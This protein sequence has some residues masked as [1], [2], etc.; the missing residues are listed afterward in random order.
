MVVDDA[1]GNICLS[2][3]GGDA[4]GEDGEEGQEGSGAAGGEVGGTRAAGGRVA[5]VL[6]AAHGAAAE[7]WSVGREAS[8]VGGLAED[9]RDEAWRCRL[10]LTNPRSKCL[11]I[12]ARNKR[13][14]N[15][16]QVLLS[17]PTRASKT[18]TSISWRST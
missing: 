4:G 3:D 5:R 9:M 8:G 13:M 15:W 6:R 18:R 2:L 12:S 10:T 11:R 1:A 14:I 16:F 7:L 17:I